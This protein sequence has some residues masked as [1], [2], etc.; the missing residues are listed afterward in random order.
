MSPVVIRGL[1]VAVMVVVLTGMAP[2]TSSAATDL[3]QACVNLAP[4]SDT[5][6][7]ALTAVSGSATMIDVTFRW[8]ASAPYQ[9]GGTGVVTESLLSPGSFDVALTGTHNTTSFG[10]NK[11]CSFFA[12]V[13]PPSFS[14]PWQATCVGS[15]GAPF[16]VSGTL[17][18]V[19]CT[20]TMSVEK[21]GPSVGD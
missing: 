5:I 21:E 9:I 7:V 12:V 1:L 10:G 14:G 15:G 11:I 16:T 6:R 4:F 3:G 13:T 20:G 17:N 8:R 19:A 2:G 18:V